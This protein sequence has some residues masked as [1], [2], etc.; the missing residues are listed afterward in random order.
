MSKRFVV[1][2]LVVSY[3]SYSYSYHDSYSLLQRP[4]TGDGSVRW[5]LETVR[6]YFARLALAIALALA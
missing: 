1:I 3:S 6:Q 5:S 4:H 2:E